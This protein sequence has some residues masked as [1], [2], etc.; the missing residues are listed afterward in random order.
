MFS[1][2]L[3]YVSKFEEK[4]IENPDIF[5]KAVLDLVNDSIKKYTDAYVNSRD[6]LED[7]LE[8]FP[9]RKYTKT[10]EDAKTLNLFI[11]DFLILNETNNKLKEGDTSNILESYRKIFATFATIWEKKSPARLGTP[12]ASILYETAFNKVY[13]N[14]Q[15]NQFSWSKLLNVY[16]DTKGGWNKFIES[17][18]ATEELDTKFATLYEDQTT[19]MDIM[20]EKMIEHY[21]KLSVAIIEKKNE[22]KT[23]KIIKKLNITEIFFK[24]IT[25]IKKQTQEDKDFMLRTNPHSEDFP[26]S[27]S[28][29][30]EKKYE[31]D[32]IE[33]SIHNIIGYITIQEAHSRWGEKRNDLYLEIMRRDALNEKLARKEV[34]HIWYEIVINDIDIDANLLD[35]LFQYDTEI[36]LHAWKLYTSNNETTKKT[37]LQK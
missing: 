12:F 19:T 35:E 3:F 27:I 28:S 10:G 30:I 26:V 36:L 24:A 33:N 25:K 37:F 32:Q 23:S 7:L 9:Y 34:S 8:N 1:T 4:Q 29:R 14:I 2:L 16:V 20:R 17:K 22:L 13:K 21:D 6:I 5:E 15:P 31:K 11:N 18:K